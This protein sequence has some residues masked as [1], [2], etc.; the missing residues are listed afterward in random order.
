VKK[1][2]EEHGGRIEVRTSERGS[3]FELFIPQHKKPEHT[4][5]ERPPRGRGSSKPPS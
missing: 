2:V 5:S 3:S 1:I 4:A